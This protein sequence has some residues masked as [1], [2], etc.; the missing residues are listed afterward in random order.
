M[1]LFFQL[2]C[3]H[4]LADFSL[5]SDD[6]AKGKNRN[7]PVDISKIPP[8]QKPMV[9]WPYWLTS[10]ALI[11]GGMVGLITGN[12]WLGLAETLIHW[13]IDFAKCENWTGIH[14]DQALHVV[15]KALWV[16]T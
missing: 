10:H 16:I 8:G 9:I 14:T 2:I 13:A 4:A 3:G 7:R 1:T 6:M 15:C 11:H 12:W 5:Q